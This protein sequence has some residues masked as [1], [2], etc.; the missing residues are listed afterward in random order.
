M[1]AS[2]VSFFYY[3]PPEGHRLAGSATVARA[4]TRV[5]MLWRS[6]TLREQGGLVWLAGRVR[7]GAIS[8]AVRQH[9][10]SK[11][12]RRSVAAE[13]LFARN[14]GSLRPYPCTCDQQCTTQVGVVHQLCLRPTAHL[15]ARFCS[16]NV[17]G[18]SAKARCRVRRL[19]GAVRQCLA[20]LSSH[21]HKYG[22][23]YY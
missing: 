14:C 19:G 1:A 5:C 21:Y 20:Y 11:N 23:V 3:E 12:S 6:W 22:H 7:I 18:T 13:A 15:D 9:S 8:D 4:P 17:L 2:R 16:S 10:W